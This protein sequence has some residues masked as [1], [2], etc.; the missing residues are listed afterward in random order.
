M[1]R[2]AKSTL[3]ACKLRIIPHSFKSNMNWEKVSFCFIM[4]FN[5]PRLMCQLFLTH[6]SRIRSYPTPNTI[7]DME[8]NHTRAAKVSSQF[9]VFQKLIIKT[10]GRYIISTM[11]L[12]KISTYH[13]FVL[14]EVSL[15]INTIKCNKQPRTMARIWLPHTHVLFTPEKKT[16]RK[17]LRQRFRN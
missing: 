12:G 11:Y 3:L 2:N 1:I 6:E 5:P 15:I 16:N 9:V 14:Q 10:A 7:S 4:L 13:E 8:L 17:S